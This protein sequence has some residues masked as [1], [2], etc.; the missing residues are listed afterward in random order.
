MT[1]ERLGGR[2]R[3]GADALPPDGACDFWL[4]TEGVMSVA[5]E[6]PNGLACF[7]Y[8][9]HVEVT[10]FA[11]PFAGVEG[12]WA[13][14]IRA[15]RV[16]VGHETVAIDQKVDASVTWPRVLRLGDHE[17]EVVEVAPT[18]GTRL[19]QRGLVGSRL[20]DVARR[21]ARL[22]FGPDL[23][24]VTGSPFAGFAARFRLRRGALP[25]DTPPESSSPPGPVGLPPV[26]V[27][28]PPTIARPLLVD[29]RPRLAALRRGRTTPGG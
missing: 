20:A 19:D 3:L 9:D 26:P 1:V 5:F 12:P 21:L 15:R 8:H 16:R 23:R 28:V 29:G 22:P 13:A 2:A 17:L 4:S 24:D 6:A 7:T 11:G 10:L 18:Q 27:P 25:A 14:A